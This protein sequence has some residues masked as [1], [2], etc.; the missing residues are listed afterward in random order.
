MSFDTVPDESRNFVTGTT[1]FIYGAVLLK[2]SDT[3]LTC[4]VKKWTIVTNYPT[5]F[6]EIT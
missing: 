1:Y 3:T 5:Q 4:T 6:N 2:N